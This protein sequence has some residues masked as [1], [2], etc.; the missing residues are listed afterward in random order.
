MKCK[1]QAFNEW[2]ILIENF[3][4]FSKLCFRKYCEKIF[5]YFPL[6]QNQIFVKQI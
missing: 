6:S 2:N 1:A 5:S 3:F 4:I